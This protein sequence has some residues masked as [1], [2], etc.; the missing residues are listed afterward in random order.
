M[1]STDT[2]RRMTTTHGF[3]V[4]DTLVVKN[5]EGVK[6]GVEEREVGI[7]DMWEGE[8]RLTSSLATRT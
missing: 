7:L 5:A 4:L 8:K 1:V 6:G 3:D 2:H